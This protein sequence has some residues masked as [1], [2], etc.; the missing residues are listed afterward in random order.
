[1]VAYIFAIGFLYRKSRK[2]TAVLEEQVFVM[3]VVHT[4]HEEEGARLQKDSEELP[5]EGASNPS[6]THTELNQ[7]LPDTISSR[8]NEC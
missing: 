1:M 7:K 4:D 2:K 8:D 5:A 3:N 6:P